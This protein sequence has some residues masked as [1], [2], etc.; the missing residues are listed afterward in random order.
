MVG[1]SGLLFEGKI[2]G[3]K[4]GKIARY[5]QGVEGEICESHTVSSLGSSDW[6]LKG[7]S[8]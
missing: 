1:S 3:E 6:P 4:L 5:G 7:F 8:K 2:N